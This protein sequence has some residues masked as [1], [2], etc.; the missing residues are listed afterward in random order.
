MDRATASAVSA[1]IDVGTTKVCTLVG[2][3]SELGGMRIVGVGVSP[4][5]GLRKGVVVNASEAAEAIV[6]SV[7]R[8]ERIS[9]YHITRAFVGIAGAHICFLIAQIVY[10]EFIMSYR[11][12]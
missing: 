10:F 1:A 9:G 4:S 12:R 6:A 11:M 5:R 3:T 2:E 7:E 8:A